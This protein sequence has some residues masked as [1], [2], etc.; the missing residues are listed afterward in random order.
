MPNGEQG[1][2]LG[3][4]GAGRR[5]ARGERPLTEFDQVARIGLVNPGVVEGEAEVE[6]ERRL[7]QVDSQGD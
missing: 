5:L 1:G 4:G 2:P 3:G 7:D 6:R